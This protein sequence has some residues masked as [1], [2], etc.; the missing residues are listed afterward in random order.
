MASTG[1][2]RMPPPPRI[3][4]TSAQLALIQKWISQGAKNNVC[5]ACDTSSFKYATSIQP[6]IQNKCVGCHNSASLG[7]GIDLSSYAAVK[8]VAVNGKLFGSVNW[9]TGF[10]PMPKGGVKSPVCEITQI[11]K[12]IDAGSLNN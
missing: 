11:K 6:L 7:G 1:S 12:W 8:A 5:D 9:A 3:P 4:I 2:S 10:S